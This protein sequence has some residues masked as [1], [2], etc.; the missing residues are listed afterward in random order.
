MKIISGNVNGIR[1]ACKKGFWGFIAKEEPDIFCLQEI[2][3]KKE[4]LPKDPTELNG[5]YP[6]FNS[7]EKKGYSGVAVFTKEKPILVKTK[8]GL[9]RFDKEG[10]YLELEYSDFILF[11][12]YLPHGGRQKENLKYKLEAYKKIIEKVRKLKNKNVILIGD[13]NIAHE[14]IDLARPKE[15]RNNIM[16]TAEERKQIDN[17]LDLGLVDSFRCFNTEQGHYTWWPYAFRAKERNLGWRIDYVFVSKKLAKKVSKAN[18]YA[19]VNF[20]D[21]C[22][23]GVEVEVVDNFKQE[24]L[25]AE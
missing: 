7:A 6:V 18:I 9:E 12:F 10:R 17:L 25:L 16:F 15:N 2:K 14:E 13:F 24:K 3:A 19:E 4:D 23:I 5:Y 22:P 1:S 11:N 20:S 21:H 8:L